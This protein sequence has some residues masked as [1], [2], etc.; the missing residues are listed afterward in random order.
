[1][2][3]GIDYKSIDVP[4]L[5]PVIAVITLGCYLEEL[6]GRRCQCIGEKS[7]QSFPFTAGPLASDIQLSWLTPRGLQEST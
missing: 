4:S 7:S 3:L 1:M 5:L 6:V 2:E